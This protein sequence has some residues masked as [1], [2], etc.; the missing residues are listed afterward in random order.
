MNFEES[1]AYLLSLGHETLAMKFG[2]E[3]SVRLFEALGEP[4]HT[5]RKV[6]LAGTNGKGS[7]AVMLDSI[8]RRAGI[9]TALYTSPHLVS[10]TE[11]M[12]YDGEA[13]DPLHFALAATSVRE[14]AEKLVASGALPA[15][16][17]FFEQLTAIFFV[18]CADYRTELAI[19][20]TGLGGR[21]DA[22]TAA[23]AEVV[24]IT[25]IALDHQEYLGETL[26]EI[27]FEK[28]AIIRP[29]VEAVIAP[30]PSEAMEVIQKRCAECV[31][32]PRLAD[33]E[34]NITGA[35]ERGRLRLT[36]KTREDVYEN[37]RLSL[38]GRHQA[39]NAAVAI[40][41]A[42]TLRGRGFQISREAIIAGIENAVHPGRLEWRDG[43]EGEPAFLFDGAHNAEG[44][45]ALRAYFDEFVK[46]PVTLVFGAMRD[47]NLTA[48]ADALFPVAEHLILTEIN[49]PR[50]ATKE[51]LQ[52]L[53]SHHPDERPATFTAHVS[54]ALRV[55]AER[56]VSGGV[57]CVTGSLYL[58]GEAQSILAYEEHESYAN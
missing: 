3:N 57:I 24:A 20:E 11:R 52:Q 50:T 19:L 43:V 16:P 7:S 38:A 49:N 51:M 25:P 47:K 23:R 40:A 15:L 2:L 45:R 54:E 42:E 21:L 41:I 37:V 6:Q 32:T 39:T 56:T 53:V 27:A 36:F 29:G 17:T 30:Q 46:A 18:G 8:T 31:V 44:A 48:M 35:D 14:V 4:Q 12:R 33:A 55:A 13:I 58:I 34:I 9:T 5:C 28:A 22:T 10:I 1:L 26:A